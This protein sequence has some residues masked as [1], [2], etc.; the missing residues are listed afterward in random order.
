MSSQPSGSVKPTTP[1]KEFKAPDGRPYYFNSVTQQSTW[2][3]PD[4]IRRIQEMEG[5]ESKAGIANASESAPKHV[6]EAQTKSQEENKIAQSGGGSQT[7]GGEEKTLAT[8][9]AKATPLTFKTKEEVRC[10]EVS[11]EDRTDY[12]C[13]LCVRLRTC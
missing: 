7:N 4:E 1:W 3:I 12:R 2:T 11:N 10:A 13:R 9:T 6:V 8:G 5:K